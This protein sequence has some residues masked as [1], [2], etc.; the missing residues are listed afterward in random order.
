MMIRRVVVKEVIERTCR[1]CADGAIRSDDGAI[2]FKAGAEAI[3]QGI[4]EL[5]HGNVVAPSGYAMA[6]YRARGLP[7][8]YS[9]AATP[10]RGR[11]RLIL[12]DHNRH[13]LGP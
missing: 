6:Q 12:N 7:S 10:N 8:I 5:G 1:L 2:M 9:A 3:K 4:F 13:H 11:R